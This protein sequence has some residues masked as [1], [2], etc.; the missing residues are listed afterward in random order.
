MQHRQHRLVAVFNC[1]GQFL[2]D[3]RLGRL[4]ELANISTGDKSL[5]CA[6]EH[7]QL[8]LLVAL[9]LHE[10]CQQPGAYGVAQGI[11]RRVVDLNQG[12]AALAG[13]LHD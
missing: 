12:H 5:P 4:A 9:R 13:Q 1:Q 8:D 3:R 7:D 6:T 11:D 10:G 2:Q